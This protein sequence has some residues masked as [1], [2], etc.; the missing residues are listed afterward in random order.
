MVND[1]ADQHRIS[2]S[3]LLMPLSYIAMMGGML[4]LIGTSSNLLASELSRELIDRPFTMFEFTQLGAIVLIITAIYLFTVG[5]WLLPERVAP[6]IDLVSEFEVEDHL[7]RLAVRETSPLVGRSV[8][9]VMERYDIDIDVLQLIRGRGIVVA[10]TPG[11]E[12]RAGDVLTVRGSE[13]ARA[14]FA[15]AADLRPVRRGGETERTLPRG[16]GTLVEVV[17][18]PGSSFIGKALAEMRIRNRYSASVLAV[19]RPGGELLRERLD[20]LVFEAG[21]AMLVHT[22]PETI[23]FWRESDDLVITE[24][25]GR[26]VLEVKDVEEGVYRP[27]KTP[28]AIG[29]F[30]AVVAVAALGYAPIAVSALGGVVAMVAT[31]V[32]SPREGYGAVN[33][34]VVFLLAGLIPLGLAM[35]ATGGAAYLAALVVSVADPLSAVL[36]LGIFYLLTAALANIVGSN[37]C[38]ILMLPVAVDA[39]FQLGA[40]PFSFILAVTFAASAPFMMP[41]GYQT[42]L[43]VYAP[44]G[45]RFSDFM[46]V[47]GPLQALLTVVVTA[48][49]VVLWGV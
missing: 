24:E 37:A 39:A 8:G 5:Q 30:A 40:D 17:V 43:M 31:G 34:Q 13:Q 9:D 36:V 21:D 25:V 23:A 4:T 41:V 48:G 22:K 44:G 14:T 19:R 33:W 3:K 27:E 7:A 32:L 2:P 12:L 28:I 15:D 29:I 45:Y 26:D 49:I 35:D 38:V 47:G 11:Q 10:P 46:R 6:A 16:N 18:P 1:L 20:E 42:N